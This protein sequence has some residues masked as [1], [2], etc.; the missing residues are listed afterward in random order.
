MQL[1]RE[2]GSGAI[3][4]VS[5]HPIGQFLPH[6]LVVRRTTRALCVFLLGVLVLAVLALVF[7]LQFLLLDCDF[8]VALGVHLLGFALG[9]EDGLGELVGSGGIKFSFSFTIGAGSGLVISGEVAF[10]SSFVGLWVGRVGTQELGLGGT[11]LLDS[12]SFGGLALGL[13]SRDF[14]CFGRLTIY[15]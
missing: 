1:E 8:S 14:S 5:I 10:V 13:G 12:R 7:G 11:S 6:H 4:P 2:D 3:H 15:Q 9:A